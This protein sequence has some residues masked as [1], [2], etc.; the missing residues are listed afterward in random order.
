MR[1]HSEVCQNAVETLRPEQEGVIVDKTEIIVD[2][3]KTRVLWGVGLSVGIAVESYQ[4]TS[5][6]KAS[7]NFCAVTSAPKGGVGIRPCRVY[8]NSIYTFMQQNRL[9]V[10]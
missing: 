8:Y 5:G 3:C 6:G 10:H 7:Q 4:T 1:R 2:E 9:M